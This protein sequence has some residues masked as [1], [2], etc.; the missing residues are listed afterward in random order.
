MHHPGSPH[1][2]ATG[3]LSL[4]DRVEARFAQLTRDPAKLQVDG[5]LIGQGLPERW[6]PLD[7]L[8]AMLLHPSTPFAAR[9]A[10]LA[11]LVGLART[12]GDDWQI[13]LLGVLAY[14][15][16][17]TTA[18]AA[19][20]YPGD[21]EEVD[22]EV[23]AGLLEAVASID[24]GPGRVASRLLWAAFRRGHAVRVREQERVCREQPEGDAAAAPV[25]PAP[26]AEPEHVLALAQV[27]GVLAAAEVRLIARTRLGGVTLAEVA[28]EQRL[29]PATIRQR[30]WRAE[31]RLRHFLHREMDIAWDPLSRLA[32]ER[33]FG[34]EA[35]LA[36]AGGTRASGLRRGP[37]LSGGEERPPLGPAGAVR[38][39][40]ALARRSRR[41]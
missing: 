36:A 11:F 6:I 30:R 21:P 35:G 26:A 12:G 17:T 10:A 14:G 32:P 3:P 4:I 2:H 34:G 8:R 39:A 22:A 7:E 24:L 20:G 19:R 41:T 25:P 29:A 40:A 5:A 16:R 27:A 13:G 37:A 9:D 15:L 18:R 31:Q 38:P 23:V 28:A 1:A 33:G